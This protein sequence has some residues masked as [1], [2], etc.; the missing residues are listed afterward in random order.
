MSR[1][2]SKLLPEQEAIRNKCFHPTGT[3]VEFPKEDVE[4]SIPAR[5]EKIVQLYPSRLAVKAGNRS[6]TYD[7]LNKI[8]NR[9]AQMILDR[10][11]KRAEPIALLLP[12]NAP[13]IAAILG[14][15][16]ARKIF[17]VLDPSLPDARI[18][19][20]LQDLQP[21]LV[22]T[23]RKHLTIAREMAQKASQLINI[24][25]LK[26]GRR[27]ENSGQ[28]I[29]PDD[30]SYIVYTSG[31]TGRPKGVVQNHRNSLHEVMIYTNGLHIC[32]HDRVALLYYCSASQ[33]LKIMLSS[34]LNGAVLCLYDLKEEG[35]GNLRNWLIQQGI[36]IYFSIPSVFHQFASTLTQQDKFP[37]LRLIQLGSDS[38]T[39]REV[40]DYKKH[41]CANSTLVI[42]LGATE[43]GTLRRY[44]IDRDSTL[45]K[46]AVPVGFPIADQEILLFDETS[47]E[48]G[49]NRVGEIAVKSRYLS[50]GYWRRPDL[51]EAVFKSDPNDPKS[52]LY[53]TG[54]MGQMLPDG[55]LYHLGRKDFQVKVRGY[56]IEVAEI[57]VALRS[58]DTI[59][60]AVVVAR[61]NGLGEA[62]LIAY[63]T[64]TAQGGP[65][66][67]EVRGFLKRKLPD[68][69]V[70]SRFV[71]MEAMPL[72]PNG[73]IDRA[74]LPVSD[75]SRPESGTPFVMPITPVEEQLAQIWS[76][77]LGIN[78]V[79]V[80]DNFFDLGGHSLAAGRVVSRVIK[81]LQL[82][83]PIRALF[84]SPTVA[85]M[86]A[87]IAQNQAK[88]ASD[89]K[90][91]RMLS[92]VETMSEEEA[93]KQLVEED[94]RERK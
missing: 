85:E 64:H 59:K 13:M 55:C 72:T 61:Q 25:E 11:G 14:V 38:V 92:E 60:E 5:F 62:Y 57:E 33:G 80:N 43:T 66:V 44:F 28:P 91:T 31:S 73:K 90:L 70:P 21:G 67:T 24:D 74:A 89:E 82:E 16:K 50:P 48:V 27:E 47:K 32:A 40:D 37:N 77:I 12:H 36:T 53:C 58:L 34:L 6:F 41:F 22:L 17:S 84:E 46:N 18:A 39:P 9:V 19:Y 68:Y 3:F 42:R 54:D 23:N 15:L 2:G 71:L 93:R 63:F 8:A 94:R 78:Q 45:F 1:R 10:R 65:S 88:K 52:R 81:T 79:G 83:L 51:T 7:A 87:I 4:Q 29:S 76:E 35:L 86:A 56:R 75:N 20:L 49:F 26:S 69:M 30:L